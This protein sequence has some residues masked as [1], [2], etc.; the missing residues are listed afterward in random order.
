[1][2]IFRAVM[3]LALLACLSPLLSMAVAEILGQI[4]GCKVDF[5]STQPCVAGGEDISGTL[6]T[7]GMMGYFLMAT[8]PVAAGVVATWI[9]V[10][11][12][13]WARRHAA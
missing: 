4:H 10:E 6:R 1:M 2:R 12:I 5:V 13:V 7:L 3:S 8:L 9:I 11:L